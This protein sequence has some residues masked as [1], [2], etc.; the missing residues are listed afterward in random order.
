MIARIFKWLTS[1]PLDRILDSID[2]KVDEQTKREEIKADVIKAAAVSHMQTRS[3][4]LKAGGFWLLAAFGAV[5]LFHF[6]AVVIYSTF[7]CADCAYPKLWT[8]A[9]LPTPMDEWEGWIILACIGG[10]SLF[11]VRK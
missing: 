2:N 8:I 5:V 1:G 6:G 9:A 4:W 3:G 11:S 7:W 10:L